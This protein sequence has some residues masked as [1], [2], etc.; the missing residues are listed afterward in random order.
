M[1][2]EIAMSHKPFTFKDRYVDLTGIYF[3]KLVCVNP[4]PNAKGCA[5]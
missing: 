1:A 3:H 4:L 5:I 2:L